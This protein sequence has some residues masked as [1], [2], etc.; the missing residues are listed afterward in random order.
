MNLRTFLT[1]IGIT[2]ILPVA[3]QQAK[4]DTVKIPLGKSSQILL[5]IGDRSDIETL[6]H[7]DFQELFNDVLTKLE[8]PDGVKKDTVIAKPDSTATDSSMTTITSDQ[9]S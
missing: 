7:Y 6:K 3:A 8:N 5:T 2:F 4:K 9:S 1:I